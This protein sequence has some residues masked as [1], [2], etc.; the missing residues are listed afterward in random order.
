MLRTADMVRERHKPAISRS[1]HCQLSPSTHGGRLLHPQRRI[2]SAVMT[3]DKL[4]WLFYY[5]QIRPPQN[6][7]PQSRKQT[8]NIQQPTSI[9]ASDGDFPNFVWQTAITASDPD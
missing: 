1:T 4:K 9:L 5:E 2:R 7:S 3:K 8:K 6:T